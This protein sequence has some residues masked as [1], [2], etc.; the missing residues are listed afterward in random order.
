MYCIQYIKGGFYNINI[1]QI[2]RKITADLPAA[3]PVK[4]YVGLWKNN[5]WTKKNH[6]R[7]QFV[8]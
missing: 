2:F 8:K 4:A 3:A 1:F 7:I 5:N 6:Y